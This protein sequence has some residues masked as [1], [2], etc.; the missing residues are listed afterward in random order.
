MSRNVICAIFLSLSLGASAQVAMHAPTT[1][2][3]QPT[4]AFARSGPV[5][6]TNKPVAKVNGAVLTDRDLVREMM[7][8]FPYAQQHGGGFP[9]EMEA[10]IRKGALDMIIFE[11]LVYQDALKRG[12]AVPQ[13]KLDRAIAE[14]KKQ[15]GSEAEFQ[16]YLKSE[17][18]G[19]MQDLR[20]KV[21]RAIIIDDQLNVLV[22]DKAKVTDAQARAY[23]QSNAKNFTSQETVSIQTISIVIPDKATSK[24]EA[25]ARQR[26]EDALKKAKAAKSYE[27]FGVLAEKVSQ[28]DW[29]VMMGD[30]KALPRGKMPAPIEKV[31]FNMKPGEVSDLIRMENSWCIVRVNA[32]NMPKAIPYDQIQA[33]LKR[34]LEAQRTEQLR[35]SLAAKLKKTAT[36]E[37]M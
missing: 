17:H 26:A 19:S 23:Y 15:F 20:E 16:A 8:I 36:I 37:V 21:R 18:G 24:Q 2:A 22:N 28:D 14:F 1:A 9:K 34:D 7:I 30:H 10:G 31:A 27:E 13:A 29:R 6:I 3:A 4:G 33:Q 12:V 5:T 25:E 35:S 32:H 11:E